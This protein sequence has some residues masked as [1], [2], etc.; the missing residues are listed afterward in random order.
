MIELAKSKLIQLEQG[1]AEVP[2][3][4][5]DTPGLSPSAVENSLAN[6]QPDNL[7]PKQALECLY[8]L[9]ELLRKKNN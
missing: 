8:Q 7:S 9:K 1:K 6:I 3:T 4:T 5:V 2:I